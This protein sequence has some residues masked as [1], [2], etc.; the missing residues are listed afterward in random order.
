MANQGG[1]MTTRA[2][3][4]VPPANG[5][6]F[7]RKIPVWGI[8]VVCVT[9]LSSAVIASYGFYASYTEMAKSVDR[10]TLAVE[11][12]RDNQTA[13]VLKMGQH[14]LQIQANTQSIIDVKR[15]VLEIQ[16]RTSW[17]PK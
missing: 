10:L 8:I 13:L 1:D 15:D 14:D 6:S 11:K 3:D 12:Q 7:D 17:G 4:P 2:N 9:F 5:F 16:K